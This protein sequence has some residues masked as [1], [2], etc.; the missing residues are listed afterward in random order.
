VIVVRRFLVLLVIAGFA[1]VAGACG[2]G[3]S[4]DGSPAPSGSGTPTGALGDTLTVATTAGGE[5][6]VTAHESKRVE[7]VVS[8]GD[9]LSPDAYGVRLTIE[10]TGAKAYEDVITDCVVLTDAEGEEHKAEV[11]M[12]QPDG[13]DMP[14]LL[15]DVRIAAGD[16]VSGWVYFALD[17]ER[18]P[19]TLTFTADGGS[20]PAAVAWSLD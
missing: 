10:N 5:L 19:G 16:E 1:L 15:Q 7:K 12:F 13:T 8:Y 17:P 20:G 2:S 14:E 3:S 18:Q 9:E 6:A 11:Y 4:T